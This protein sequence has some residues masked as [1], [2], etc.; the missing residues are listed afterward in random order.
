MN[1]E[2]WGKILE[3]KS[4][5]WNVSYYLL[6]WGQKKLLKISFPYHVLSVSQVKVHTYYL[7][8]KGKV[9]CVMLPLD[10]NK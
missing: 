3:E 1:S 5:K 10:N 8:W 4:V 6:S 7:Q 9:S 2:V